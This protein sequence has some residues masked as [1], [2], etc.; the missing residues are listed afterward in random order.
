MFKALKTGCK[1][2]LCVFFIFALFLYSL[3]QL[4]SLNNRHNDIIVSMLMNFCEYLEKKKN[5][6][7]TKFP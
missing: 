2:I 7:M 3:Y 4:N 6:Y 1:K 5:I